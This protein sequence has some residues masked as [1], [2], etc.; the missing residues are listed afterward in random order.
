[1]A[2]ISHSKTKPNK[3]SDNTT[4]PFFSKET[5]DSER[6]SFFPQTASYPKPSTMESS[7]FHSNTNSNTGFFQGKLNL[8]QPNDRYEQ[9]ADRISEQIVHDTEIDNV[10]SVFLPIQTK[11]AEDEPKSQDEERLAEEQEERISP[12]TATSAGDDE[13]ASDTLNT[14]QNDLQ[15]SYGQGEPLPDEVRQ[16]MQNNFKQDFSDVRIHTDTKAAQMSQSIHAKAFT[17]QNRIYFNSGKFNPGNREGLQL[18]AHELTHVVQQT[19]GHRNQIINT[20]LIQ[21]EDE[22]PEQQNPE[23]AVPESSTGE[24]AAAEQ[25]ASEQGTEQTPLFDEVPRYRRIDYE[26]ATRSNRL[27]FD[28]LQLAN[29]NPLAPYNP[30]ETPNAFI[31][32]V[33][34]WQRRANKRKEGVSLTE[35]IFAARETQESIRIQDVG[36]GLDTLLQGLDEIRQQVVSG[37]FAEGDR[38]EVDGVLGPA[39]YWTM[40]VASALQTD[41]VGSRLIQILDIPIDMLAILDSY[42]V[43]DLE[44]TWRAAHA[45]LFNKPVFISNRPTVVRFDILIETYE[46][47]FS[48]SDADHNYLIELFF[49]GNLPE[50]IEITNDDLTAILARGYGETPVEGTV[51]FFEVDR[52]YYHIVDIERLLITERP[53]WRSAEG[54]NIIMATGNWPLAEQLMEQLG[55]TL[56]NDPAAQTAIQRLQ[57]QPANS[58]EAA[59]QTDSKTSALALVYKPPTLEANQWHEIALAYADEK[60]LLSEAAETA[61][62]EYLNQLERNFERRM[63]GEPDIGQDDSIAFLELLVGETFSSAQSD[64]VAQHRR[65]AS[66][67][68]VEIIARPQAARQS[69][70]AERLYRKAQEELYLIV[71]LSEEREHRFPL[72][73]NQIDQSR[74]Q[75][76]RNGANPLQFDI[77]DTPHAA[78]HTYLPTRFTARSADNGGSEAATNGYRLTSDDPRAYEN[79]EY[80]EGNAR[81][82]GQFDPVLVEI[83]E[84]NP[85]AG[86][87]VRSW[88]QLFGV[89]RIVVRHVWTLGGS[90]VNLNEALWSAQ[91][92]V[93]LFGWIDAIL[94]IGAL[95][96]VVAAPL[97]AGGEAAAGTAGTLGGRAAINAAMRQALTTALKRFVISETIG[98]VLGRA[99]YY[100]NDDENIP[101]E[102]KT[103]WNGLMLALLIYGIGS[104]VKQ[105]IKSFRNRGSV[106]FRQ[107][108]ALLEEELE[109]ESRAAGQ[110]GETAA[111]HAAQSEVRHM[112]EEQFRTL[113]EQAG[114]EVATGPSRVRTDDPRTA[115]IGG[116]PNLRSALTSEEASRLR[117]SLG[118]EAFDRLLENTSELTQRRLSQIGDESAIQKLGQVFTPQELT[119]LLASMTPDDL[120]SFASTLG[121]AELRS[122]L[123][124]FSGNPAGISLLRTF[125]PDPQ[126]L[127][128]LF[129]LLGERT[130]SLLANN[131]GPERFWR[132][133]ELVDPAA[134]NDALRNMGRGTRGS[135]TRFRN[136][137]ND[138]GPELT[139][140]VLNMYTGRQIR[141]YWRRRGGM[142]AAQNMARLAIR[143]QGVPTQTRIRSGIPTTEAPPRPQ[144]FQPSDFRSF[145]AIGPESSAPA[146][147]RGYIDLIQRATATAAQQLET[148]ID[149]AVR[150]ALTPEELATVPPNARATVE[151][152]LRSTPTDNNHKALYG[153]ALQY[154]AEAALRDINGGS[155]PPGMAIRRREVRSGQVLIPDAQVEITLQTELRFPNR[156]TSERLVIDWTTA[157]DAG[158]ITKYAG[159]QPPVTYAVEIIQPGPPPILAASPAT[160]PIPIIPS[161]P[162]APPETEE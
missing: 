76:N 10:A 93:N 136:L 13:S 131:P 32:Q 25:N 150:G 14:L 52:P 128:R 4:Q 113:V 42:P 121:E 9:E 66:G 107:Q 147:V 64:R 103:T 19:G 51:S 114:G 105:G 98:E 23:Q 139:A 138:V 161:M 17:H 157:G 31:N 94:T 63:S 123:Q 159:G 129:D 57:N 152:F 43:E 79:W 126:R 15:R 68:D 135:T 59:S 154:L 18:L 50:N 92:T 160:V 158:K 81:H 137:L 22:E 53:E 104:T 26:E 80:F 73:L 86:Q 162:T 45:F 67:Y 87:L 91:G 99:T 62:I 145:F 124:A 146:S 44:A 34:D 72:P 35:F 106:R 75:A 41:P 39:T 65:D 153:S 148:L 58:T 116:E 142:T 156:N 111:E 38:I 55:L 155:L 2:K 3:S 46:T 149:S 100:I 82:F 21:R 56:P 89:D 74:Q 143:R 130:L 101:D 36:T 144:H 6:P 140:E 110:A 141:Q 120:R 133:A 118:D 151:A 83:I 85:E 97:L 12:K 95:A 132:V 40:L 119:R 24:P 33:A 20:S 71:Q 125:V 8:G 102:L 122:L 16:P 61:T 112:A 54:F 127:Y 117:S 77:I 70:K 30:Y 37:S 90:L 29:A 96:S 1:M 78:M 27:W 109:A 108:L 5:S 134:L 47:H 60:R 115:G 28:N 84:F 49:E 48:F 11:A 69:G 88:R 7:S